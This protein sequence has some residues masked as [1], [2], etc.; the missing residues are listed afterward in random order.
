MLNIGPEAATSRQIGLSSSTFVPLYS[1]ALFIATRNIVLELSNER[2][3]TFMDYIMTTTVTLHKIFLYCSCVTLASSPGP[4][5]CGEHTVFTSVRNVI[6]KQF[7][8]WHDHVHSVHICHIWSVNTESK[9]FMQKHGKKAS[10]QVESR[11][12]HCFKQRKAC[13]HLA[14]SPGPS[15]TCH[16][17]IQLLL[18]PCTT[19]LA[20]NNLHRL[21]ANKIGGHNRF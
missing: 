14:S 12:L 6:I 4:L 17:T 10:C 7:G 1:V 19:N 9:G 21:L 3:Q 13:I 8:Y 15:R 16:E 2:H 20:F 5:P 11:I 18:L